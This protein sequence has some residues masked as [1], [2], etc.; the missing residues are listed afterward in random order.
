MAFAVVHSHP[1]Q[2]LLLRQDAVQSVQ[3]LGHEPPLQQL[4]PVFQ[5]R[6]YDVSDSNSTGGG[7]HPH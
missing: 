1:D 6:C 7:E 3:A 2:R 5:P 4:L